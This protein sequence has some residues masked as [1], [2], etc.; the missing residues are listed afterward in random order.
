MAIG[1]AICDA[2]TASMIRV[3][4]SN[5]QRAHAGN[6][7]RRGDFAMAIFRPLLHAGSCFDRI[8]GSMLTKK[9]LN[10]ASR[11]LLVVLAATFLSPAFSWEAVASH[12][13]TFLAHAQDGPGHHEDHEDHDAVD[14]EH[15][16]HEAGDHG[17]A[18]HLLT[19]LPAV[20]PDTSAPPAHVSG[21]AAYL[22]HCHAFLCADR[23]P[24]YIPPR[25]L[26]FV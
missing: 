18:G 14:A 25:P 7:R 23:A 20:L 12:S 6:S 13:D 26:P 16:G 22:Q 9:I 4:R 8:P 1:A 17:D 5:W 24:P 15:H 21:Q 11:L 3:V 2:R 19:H 10:L